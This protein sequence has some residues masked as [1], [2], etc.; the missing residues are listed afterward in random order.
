MV[1]LMPHGKAGQELW[2]DTLPPRSVPAMPSKSCPLSVTETQAVSYL[3]KV[4]D[5]RTSVTKDLALF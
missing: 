2:R 5:H 3:G 4:S 1:V